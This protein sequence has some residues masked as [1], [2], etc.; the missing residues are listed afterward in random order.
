[1]RTEDQRIAESPGTR[2]AVEE[3]EAALIEHY[4]RLVRLA[5]I[6]LPPGLGRHRR[7][8]AA[9]AVVQ[10][11][12]PSRATRAAAPARG[13]HRVP[14]QRGGQGGPGY[15]LVR[16]EVL[17]AALAYDH[18][19]G[20]WPG[21]LPA[22]RA[23]RPTLPAVYGL[24][25]FPRSGGAD[26]LA[27]EQAL[28][29]VDAGARAAFALR[30]LDGL[31]EAETRALLT[32]AR[33]PD[34]GAAVRASVRLDR[35]DAAGAEGAGLLAS[36]EFDP[37]SVH[38]RPTDLIRRRHRTRAAAAAAAVLVAATVAVPVVFGDGDEG[39]GVPRAAA[40]GPAE[41]G[42][43][44]KAIDP[45]LLVRAPGERWADTSRV[46]FTAW[47]ARGDRRE[48]TGLLGR[49]LQ[50]WANPAKS[51]RITST[52]STPTVPPAVP[53]RLLYA[54][55]VDGTAVV[56][57]HDGQRA[58]R[59]AEPLEGGGPPVLDFART[60]DAGVTTAAALVLTRT[61][62]N[63]RYLLAPWVAETGSRDLLRPDAPATPVDVGSDGVSAPVPRPGSG[64]SCATWP[65]LQLR[66]SQKIVEKHAFLVTDLGDI[67]AVHLTYTP[68]P[69]PG[70]SGA[71]ARARQP[72]EALSEAALASWARSACYLD[73][74]RGDGVRAVNNWEY[75]RQDLPESA[76]TASWVCTRADTWQG[77]GK[78]LVQLQTPADRPAAPG[79]LV[80]RDEDTAAC[81]RF[82]QHVLAG[83][84]WQ[85]GSGDWYL[86]AAGSRHVNGI[87]SSGGVKA[88]SSG[89]T[90]A[91][92]APKGARA[93]LKGRLKDGG[94]LNAL[95]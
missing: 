11:A 38:T 30:R 43:R 74:L 29:G 89:S 44:A 52:P 67:A 79:A 41:D 37:T 15:V 7:V 48:D 71:A 23:L 77:P 85:A 25:L 26:E 14:A 57:L 20:W 82:G 93:E 1:M 54:G 75:A 50:V 33:W 88:E 16:E 6:T 70:E 73:T 80:A 39:D 12:L 49:A 28:S 94:T 60:D 31:T 24:R 18:R 92:R 35:A 19:P 91:V 86:I 72:R 76:G 81:S 21:G 90:L 36:D 9:H 84:S 65:V 46:D 10:R 22:P 8:L 59:Y 63:A 68:A 51:V 3:A 95:R 56:L 13:R 55:D 58:V 45:S 64:A 66:S 42:V 27:L 2:V 83:A 5:Y 53:P 61:D 4:A 47:P 78:V 62:G 34:A 32:A 40:T 87:V 17:R 69:A